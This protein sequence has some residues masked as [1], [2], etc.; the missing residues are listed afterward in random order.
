MVIHNSNDLT[1]N[2]STHSRHK[3]GSVNVPATKSDAIPSPAENAVDNKA[4]S[5]QLS[6]Q[7]QSIERLETKIQYSEG[8]DTAK[9][10]QLKQSIADGSYEVN[11]ERLAEKLLN[12]E[13]LLG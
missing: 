1:S 10:D 13:N 5:V 6:Q 7:A 3:A 12:H 9:V 4:A 8:V 11:S 2:T